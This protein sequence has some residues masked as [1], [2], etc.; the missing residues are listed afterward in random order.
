FLT[1]VHGFTFCRNLPCTLSMTTLL[2]QTVTFPP[3]S[4]WLRFTLVSKNLQPRNSKPIAIFFQADSGQMHGSFAGGIHFEEAPA[5]NCQIPV[6]LF[7]SEIFRPPFYLML[8]RSVSDLASRGTATG[9][10]PVKCELLGFS[11]MD[12]PKMQRRNTL[13]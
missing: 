12:R 7:P 11:S 3:C 5:G 10:L 2:E 1:S 9:K 4:R 13:L 8:L 6:A